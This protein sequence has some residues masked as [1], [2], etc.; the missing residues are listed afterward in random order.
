[1]NTTPSWVTSFRRGFNDLWF[2]LSL[3]VAL[4][5][6]F[7]LIGYH[8]SD[9]AWTT[10]GAYPKPQHWFGSAGAYISD[11]F[12]SFF[13]YAAY[14][15]PLGLLLVAW[16]SF[17]RNIHYSELIIWKALGILVSVIALCGIF[18]FHIPV[19][20]NAWAVTGGGIIG[21]KLSIELL[22]FCAVPMI[23]ALYTVVLMI[24]LVLLADVH[25]LGV[26][27]WIGYRL[28]RLF[29][30]KTFDREEHQWEDESETFSDDEDFS[31]EED[32][33]WSAPMNPES[34]PLKNPFAA[35]EKISAEHSSESTNEPLPLWNPETYSS[36]PRASTAPSSETLSWD[37][38]KKNHMHQEPYLNLRPKNNHE[39]LPLKSAAPAPEKPLETFLAD[40]DGSDEAEKSSEPHI[41]FT[42]APA[43]T[44]ASVLPRAPEAITPESF[45]DDLSDDDDDD[46]ADFSEPLL[47]PL[48]VQLKPS[49]IYQSA[50]ADHY[51]LP[52][53]HLLKTPPPSVS[54]Y[55]DEELDAMAS[56][57][58]ESLKNY[59][60]DVEVRNIE[61]GPVVTRLELA[62]AAG[63]KVS[64]ISSL[65]KD[66]A[67]SLAVQSV[68]V[69]EVIPGKPYIGLE[70]PNRKREIVHLRSILESEAYQNQKSPLT[71]VLGSD[72][73][74]N[75]VVANLAKMPHLLVAGTT[76]SGKSV[77]INVMLASMLYKATPKELRL[78]LVD[79]KMLEM[80]MYEDIPHLL[81]PVV[82]D[83]NDAENVLRWAV[84]EMERRYQLMA[85]FRVRNIAGFNQAIRSME[86]RGERIDDPLW[87]PDGLGIAHQPPQISTL[88]YIVII[89]DELA[90][91]M[92]AVGKKVEEL[93]ARI[94]QKARAAGIHLI[95]ATQRPSVD[96]ITGLIKANVPTRLAFQVSSKIDS[97]TIIEQQGA[98]SLLGYGDG[99][100]VPPGSAAPQR[101]HGAFIDD[102]EVDALTTYL[103]TQG[104]PE[105][106]ESVTHPVPPSALGA[107]G[108]LEKSDDPEQD[109]LYDEACQLVIENQKASIS[110]L[111]RRLSIGYNR[112]ARLIETMECAGIVS[113]PNNG[114]RKV[115]VGNRND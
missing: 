106:E 40:D 57:V 104:A 17:T 5:L 4:I 52:S 86:E 63:I 103:K 92:M 105:Y 6:F 58:E 30:G 44:I 2:V 49:P 83:M 80:S 8:A 46:D 33:N 50:A 109:P 28:L 48:K 66:I 82:T 115:L 85:A 111:Q 73:S 42:A 25:W 68:R 102:A 51:V 16:Q 94:A 89:I 10:S 96:V 38:F 24:G 69:V 37:A 12:I 31:D 22:K 98:E 21:Q 53:V 70:I 29:T 27:D 45:A 59:R 62:L 113:S 3:I 32:F 36:A 81:T 61:V 64:Q 101:I 11:I 78:I 75:P 39:P 76:G 18:S 43:D 107:L 20:I 7:L 87:E 54:D 1:M 13:G 84:A 23:M 72:I 67:R 97:R 9:P 35:A 108:A 65:D 26:C 55:S 19:P 74:G 79:P 112:S 114:T 15:F 60:L 110:W 88:P 95:L 41:S 91:M 71:L 77:A 47:S 93:I 14:G 100:F 99:L 34:A 90:D 56:K